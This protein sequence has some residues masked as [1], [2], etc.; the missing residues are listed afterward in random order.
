MKQAIFKGAATA[1]YTPITNG[2]IDYTALGELIKR[3]TEEKIDALVV[4]GTTGEAATITPKERTEIIKFSVKTIGKRVPLIVGTG[5]N[6]T[7][8]FVKQTKEAKELGANCALAVTPY[9]N[10][11]NT[12]GLIAHFLAAD[13]LCSF[14]VIV[15]NVPSRT[16]L[17]VSPETYT[18][19]ADIPSVIGIKEANADIKHIE[20]VFELC[21]DKLPIYCGS[22]EMTDVFCTLGASGTISILSN[23]IPYKIHDYI[24]NFE[25]FYKHDENIVATYKK[26]S[27]LLFIDVN[28]IPL[29]ALVEYYFKC[30]FDL[31]LPLT[32]LSKDK[33]TYLANEFSK[34]LQSTEIC[35]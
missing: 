20:K 18:K 33:A 22:D 24:M 31:R 8:T 19:L 2:R 5:S 10:K 17:N 11:C 12:D 26:L 29:K 3:Q 13:K 30:G 35:K 23:I 14:P 21:K 27:E 7:K 16:G 34:I 9:Y 4:L 15:Y 1:L 6:C 28:P 32:K 25:K